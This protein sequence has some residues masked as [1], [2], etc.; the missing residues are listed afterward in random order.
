MDNELRTNAKSLSQEQQL[1][2]AN[3]TVTVSSGGRTYTSGPYSVTDYVDIGTARTN[4]P[5][6]QT[7]FAGIGAATV[8]FS[9]IPLNGSYTSTQTLGKSGIA[10][11]AN[12]EQL[13]WVKW[14]TP[15]TPGTVTINVSTPVPGTS[16]ASN[17]YGSLS[18]SRI[19]CTIQDWAELE[20]PDPKNTDV[21][22]CAV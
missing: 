4:T 19:V 21:R 1:L 5:T 3:Q 10:V 22:P 11:P 14:K 18:T 16:T 2:R 12:G 7:P 13:V 8:A 6:S 9:G 17:K 15:S 20:P